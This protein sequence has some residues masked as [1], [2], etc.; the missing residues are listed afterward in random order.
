MPKE[1]VPLTPQTFIDWTGF[2]NAKYAA[3]ANGHSA[4]LSFRIQPQILRVIQELVTEYGEE[5]KE[6]GDFIRHAIREHV[7]RLTEYRHCKQHDR[8]TSTMAQ[9]DSM[10]NTL[11]YEEEQANFD[12][13]ITRAQNVINQL[14]SKGAEAE[15]ARVLNDLRRDMEK[16]TSP[17]WR[18]RYLD[19][20][21]TRFGSMEQ[22][23]K[24][25]DLTSF[26]GY[27][28]QGE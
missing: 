19:E 6:Y 10:L 13:V 24:G 3:D 17:F 11:Q 18:K 8:I 21:K 5:Y 28:T 16:I 4:R 22:T 26:K 2:R 15:V 27:K 9:V 12:Q 25:M 14:Y 20:M 23:I 1:T 7:I